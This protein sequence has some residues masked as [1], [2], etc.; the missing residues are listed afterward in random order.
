MMLGILSLGPCIMPFEHDGN[1]S[2]VGGPLQN[3]KGCENK[4]SDLVIF[5]NYVYFCA[6]NVKIFHA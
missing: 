3:V 2:L 5:G 6:N 4:C 1:E